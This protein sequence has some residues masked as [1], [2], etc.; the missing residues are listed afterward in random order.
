[1]TNP[2]LKTFTQFSVTIIVRE[3][4]QVLNHSYE[5]HRIQSTLQDLN[6]KNR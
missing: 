2:I 5:N 6:Y 1:M 3:T 4:E